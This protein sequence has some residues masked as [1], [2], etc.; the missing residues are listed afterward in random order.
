M[1][2]V[3]KPSSLKE[4]QRQEREALILQTA[5]EAFLAHG[6]HETSLDEIATRVGISK[7]TIYQHFACKED[8]LVAL[9]TVGM[10][11][12]I[13]N[14]EEAIA[15]EANAVARLDAL[16]ACL[17]SGWDTRKKQVF[18]ALSQDRELQR[19]FSTNSG[20]LLALR[21][22]IIH[23]VIAMFEEGKA[24]GEFNPAL[25]TQAMA[26]ALFSFF[27]PQS[28]RHFVDQQGC[29]DKELFDGLRQILFQGIQSTPPT[30]HT[31]Q[32]KG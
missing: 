23:V 17:R 28:L 16:I 9:A 11:Q 29:T 20:P 13:K 24:A 25:P 19:V 8:L 18:I 32:T 12:L 26:V 21:Q 14:V 10:E 7:G 31:E 4:R 6:Y 2:S 5:E 15:S 27:S 1:Q 30:L 22:R 3:H